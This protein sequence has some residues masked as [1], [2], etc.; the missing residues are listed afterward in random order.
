MTLGC[1]DPESQIAQQPNKPLSRGCPEGKAHLEA[2]NHQ[3]HGNRGH[4]SIRNWDSDVLI[5]MI[6]DE[7]KLATKLEESCPSA[8]QS[9]IIL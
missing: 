4:D 8:S 3:E 1:L 9:V 2:Q 5:F 7:W 6:N